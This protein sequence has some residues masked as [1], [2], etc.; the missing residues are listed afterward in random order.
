MAEV[1]GL[2]VKSYV[3]LELNPHIRLVDWSTVQLGLAPELDT[4]S[5]ADESWLSSS[6]RLIK[7]L[8]TTQTSRYML[9]NYLSSDF[10]LSISRRDVNS[11]QEKPRKM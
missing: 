5:A 9:F 4:A 7:L 1:D 8:S 3:R 10:P 6:K 11:L 2:T